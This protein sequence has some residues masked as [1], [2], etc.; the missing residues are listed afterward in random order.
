MDIANLRAFASV[1]ATGSFSGA[2]DQ[3]HLTQ[4]AVSKRV[5]ILEDELGAQ[6]FD[7]LGRRTELTEAG[8]ALLER[9]P[10]VENSLRLAAQA[11]RDLEGELTGPLR[12]A[13]SHHI[14][15][16]RLPP[17]LSEFQRRYPH[18]NLDIE[19]LD[20]EQAYER[21]RRG[22][23]ELAVVTLAPGNV[24]QLSSEPLW[25]D[26][27]RVMVARDHEL[28]SRKSV[29]I[30]ALASYPAI[31]PGLET[32]TGQIVRRHFAAAGLSLELR[33]AT[34]YLETLRM[35]ASV[36]LGWTVLPEFMAGDSLVSLEV[37]RTTLTR[38]LGLVTHSERSASRGA[39]AFLNLLREQA[40]VRS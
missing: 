37:P 22:V 27:L 36:G 38:T 12:I 21:L 6:L 26:Q 13:T 2:A 32:F 28:A 34:N 24:S 1:A 8:R 14:G 30:E 17:V 4:P 18:V 3:L 23:I 39:T 5:A 10:D 20:S 19:F 16:H 29:P 7:R 33:M 25:V 9:V 15:L 40:E 31:L 11:V 35:M